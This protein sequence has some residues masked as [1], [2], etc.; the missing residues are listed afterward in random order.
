MHVCLIQIVAIIWYSLL[1]IIPWY[2]YYVPGMT[3]CM[4]YIRPKIGSGNTIWLCICYIYPQ[5]SLCTSPTGHTF[6]SSVGCTIIYWN[7]HSAQVYLEKPALVSRKH[8]MDREAGGV[9]VDI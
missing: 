5:D 7:S 2:R 4:I 1:A 9:A 3:S 6:L 8:K